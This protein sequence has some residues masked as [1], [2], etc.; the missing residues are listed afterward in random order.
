MTTSTRRLRL[1]LPLLLGGCG[2]MPSEVTQDQDGSD[3][4]AVTGS[5]GST[6]R[7]SSSTA[8]PGVDATGIATSDATGIESAT[9]QGVEPESTGSASTST[10]SSSTSGS[11]ST[12]QTGTEGSTGPTSPS[13]DDLYGLAPDYFLCLETDDECHFNATTGGSNCTAMCEMFLGTCL[14]AFDNS[15]N[16]NIIRPNM[17]HCGTNRSNEICVCSK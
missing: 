11:T 15:T 13:C 3:S 10:T 12:G 17:D 6:S 14:A 7:G 1:M 8:G 4:S 9:T 5:S 2:P 16:C